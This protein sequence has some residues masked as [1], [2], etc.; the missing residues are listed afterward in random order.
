MMIRE[1]KVEGHSSRI[2]DIRK[3]HSQYLVHTCFLGVETTVSN[4]HI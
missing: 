3:S 2:F 4:S 1:G